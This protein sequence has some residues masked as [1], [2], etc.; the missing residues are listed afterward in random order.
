MTHANRFLTSETLLPSA[1]LAAWELHQVR[2]CACTRCPR[3]EEW[4]ESLRQNSIA[5]PRLAEYWGRPL[6]GFGDPH[7]RLLIVG[8]APSALGS[9]RTGR[10]FTGD[11]CGQFLFAA[12]HRAGFANHAGSYGFGDALILRDAFVTGVG[13]C[14][15]P[16][17][18]PEAAELDACQVFLER[19]LELLTRVEGVVAMGQ[20]A[21]RRLLTIMARRGASH[22]SG[23]FVHGGLRRLGE[24]FP[25][26]LSSY[27]PS[28]QNTQTGRLTAA[29]FDEIWATARGLL[30]E[31]RVAE[32]AAA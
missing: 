18:R 10:M 3:L 8:L 4:G 30:A 2:I 5:M 12:L 6:P 23:P 13:R 24:G 19:E 7:A 28:R 17:N 29:M 27:H 16:H 11:P 9:F 21:H 15:A 14:P 32:G 1:E 31:T 20:V 22:A 25:W 26:L